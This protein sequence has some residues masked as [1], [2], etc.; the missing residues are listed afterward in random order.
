MLSFLSFWILYRSRTVIFGQNR[1]ANE[2]PDGKLSVAHAVVPM[3]RSFESEDDDEK[4]W[5]GG[6]EEQGTST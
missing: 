5:E 6:K 2:L 1:R 3:A 4:V